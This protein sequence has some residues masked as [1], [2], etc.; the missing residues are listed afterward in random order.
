MAGLNTLTEEKF[1]LVN[2]YIGLL[3]IISEAFGHIPV[4]LER[5]NRQDWTPS[6][7]GKM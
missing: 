2:E 1:L 6:N 4:S 7:C 3:D 5:N